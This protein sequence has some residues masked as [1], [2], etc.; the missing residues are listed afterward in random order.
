MS[1]LEGPWKYRLQLFGFLFWPAMLVPK[2]PQCTP[3]IRNQL[4]LAP[5]SVEKTCSVYGQFS[6]LGFLLLRRHLK[7]LQKGPPFTEK[8][9][10]LSCSGAEFGMDNQKP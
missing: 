9:L 5:H 10:W 7:G 4:P 8:T 1:I 6:K 3:R 2:A